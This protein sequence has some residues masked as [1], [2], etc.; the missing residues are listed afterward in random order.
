M[1]LDISGVVSYMSREIKLFIMGIVFALLFPFD[2]RD[3]S[4]RLEMFTRGSIKFE[5]LALNMDQVEEYDPP[6]N[7]AKTTDSR[8]SAYIAEFGNE[9]WELDALEPTVLANL[10]RTSI[11]KIVDREAM[12]G[13]EAEQQ[14]HRE[15]LG[16]I[17]ERFDEVEE[18]LNA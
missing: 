11:E 8:A 4:D 13:A 12:D 5:R 7:P 14:R 17:A 16:K 1:S 15:T 18:F 10:V 3:I 9:S 2:D 6:P